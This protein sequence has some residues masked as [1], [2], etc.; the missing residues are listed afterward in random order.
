MNDLL[1]QKIKYLTEAINNNTENAKATFAAKS[2][3]VDNVPANVSIGKFNFNVD[4]PKEKLENPIDIFE[5][6]CTVFDS[7]KEQIEITG[8]VIVKQSDAAA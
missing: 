6:L 7:L 8:K 5:R 3:L 4:V 2:Y 1:A